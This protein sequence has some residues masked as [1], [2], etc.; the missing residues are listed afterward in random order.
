M[1]CPRCRGLVVTQYEETRCLICG[2]MKNDPLPE[3]AREPYWR[4]DKC[5]NCARKAVTTKKHCQVCLD[6]MVQYRRSRK[7]SA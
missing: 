6:Y 5:L 1:T 4:I 3:P 7:V 2:W